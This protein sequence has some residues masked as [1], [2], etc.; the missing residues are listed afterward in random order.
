MLTFDPKT[1]G[2]SEIALDA[3]VG[4]FNRTEPSAYDK[5]DAKAILA[6][7]DRLVRELNA[8][9]PP[10]WH[11]ASHWGTNA[12]DK[13]D[14]DEVEVRLRSRLQSGRSTSFLPIPLPVSSRSA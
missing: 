4:K 10:G 2:L 11:A 1:H 8:S 5:L 3:P 7:I 9:L 12:A 6:S 14:I 13:P